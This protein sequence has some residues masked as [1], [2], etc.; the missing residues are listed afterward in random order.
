MHVSACLGQ[1]AMAGTIGHI[2]LDPTKYDALSYIHWRKHDDITEL[3]EERRQPTEGDDS[4]DCPY[5]T[6]V[7]YLNY[8]LT[9]HMDS[10]HPCTHLVWWNCDNEWEK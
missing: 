8:I 3:T 7:G 10:M 9:M 1:S 5:D 4:D 2:L 6:G